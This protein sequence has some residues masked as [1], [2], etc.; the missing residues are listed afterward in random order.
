MADVSVLSSVVDFNELTDLVQ[1]NLQY[2]Y[3]DKS[4]G[5]TFL[6]GLYMISENK[7]LLGEM[8]VRVGHTFQAGAAPGVPEYST[9]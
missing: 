2:S 1:S 9:W 4:T 6:T 8:W 7:I 3:Q 5:H